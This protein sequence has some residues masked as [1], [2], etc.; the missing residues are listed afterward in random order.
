MYVMFLPDFKYVKDPGYVTLVI[1]YYNIYF[2]YLFCHS[3]TLIAANQLYF[4][5][6]D[7]R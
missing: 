3:I 6:N 7:N 2:M 1:H 5:P 4:N